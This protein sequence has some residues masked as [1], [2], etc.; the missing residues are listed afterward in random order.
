MVYL[1]TIRMLI[2]FRVRYQ[3][4]VF[5]WILKVDLLTSSNLHVLKFPTIP[6][7]FADNNYEL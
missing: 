2:L 5:C 7:P 3:K 1:I 4:I 6:Y